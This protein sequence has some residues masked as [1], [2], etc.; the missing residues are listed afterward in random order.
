MPAL[1]CDQVSELKGRKQWTC[2]DCRYRFSA[3]AGTIFH[4]SHI[5]LR[6]WFMAIFIV[7]NAKKSLSSLQLKREL[8]ISQE[9]C[10]H[11]VHRIREAMREGTTDLFHGSVQMDEFF[12]ADSPVPRQRATWESRTR[13]DRP[14]VIGAVEA[15]TGRIRTKHVTNTK[16]YTVLKL[17]AMAGHSECGLAYRPI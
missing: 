3:T 4:K 1:R 14:L 13:T 11:M 5:G 10:W 8:K 6:K 17:E 15:S 7:L 9:C 16:K 12:L 2:F